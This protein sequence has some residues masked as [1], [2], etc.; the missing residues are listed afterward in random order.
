M[1]KGDE[2]NDPKNLQELL[3]AQKRGE[4]ITFSQKTNVETAKALLQE[5]IAIMKENCRLDDGYLI[6]SHVSFQL[7]LL[8]LIIHLAEDLESVKKRR[9]R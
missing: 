5:Q 2:M 6:P 1:S 8:H 4:K 9:P 3:D 7:R